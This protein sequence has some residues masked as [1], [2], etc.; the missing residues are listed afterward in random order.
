MIAIDN[1][2]WVGSISEARTKDTSQFNTIVTVCQDCIEDNVSD[3]TNYHCYRI[4]DGPHTEDM[5]GGST[6]YED[7]AAAVD[8]VLN[9]E[10]PTLVHC[11]AGQS[12]SIAVITTVLAVENDMNWFKQF[13][14]VRERRPTANPEQLLVE[15][16]KRYLHRNIGGEKHDY[17]LLDES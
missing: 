8:T 14:E 15:H 17:Y 7:F 5:Y 9:G 16:A 4:A 11:H 2:I 1:G 10:R 13:Q 3:T 12:R 6:E